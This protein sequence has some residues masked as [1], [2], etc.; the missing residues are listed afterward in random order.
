MFIIVLFS[1]GEG[2]AIIH[3]ISFEP[4]TDIQWLP[5]SIKRH[6]ASVRVCPKRHKVNT[7][8]IGLNAASSRLSS[9]SDSKVFTLRSIVTV[10]L[11]FASVCYEF[12]GI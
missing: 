6:I 9:N 2:Q 7:K 3:K 12:N 1:Q 8:E 10:S 5:G 4:F 11:A